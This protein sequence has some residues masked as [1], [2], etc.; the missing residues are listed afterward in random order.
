ML[1]K[2][3]QAIEAAQEEVISADQQR[4]VVDAFVRYRIAD[5]LA[6]Y[7]TLRDEAT[8]RTAWSP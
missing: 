8:A 5:P 3:N 4:L 1:D 6:F 2:R 7:R